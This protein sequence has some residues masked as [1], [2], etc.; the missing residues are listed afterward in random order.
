MDGNIR[1]EST[2]GVGSTFLVT[3]PIDPNLRKG[4]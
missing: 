3:L 1:V 4:E 2:V